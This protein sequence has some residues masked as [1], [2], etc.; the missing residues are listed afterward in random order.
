MTTTP[1][2][3][4]GLCSQKAYG[5]SSHL[6]RGISSIGNHV[7]RS[8]FKEAIVLEMANMGSPVIQASVRIV[9]VDLCHATVLF[10][11]FA[12]VSLSR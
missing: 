11:V 4:A 2:P 3:Q 10:N 6:G 5:D 8:Y 12:L 1:T 9:L 7:L